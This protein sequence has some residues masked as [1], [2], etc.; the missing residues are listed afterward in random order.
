VDELLPDGTGSIRV[1]PNP[2]TDLINI[3]FDLSSSS[4]INVSVYD[5]SGKLITELISREPGSGVSSLV[6]DGSDMESGVYIV[7]ISG[8][9][10]YHSN[11]VIKR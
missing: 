1:H 7:T 4:Y 10:I 6:W 8:K 11:I 2:F 3:N 5:L 9:D